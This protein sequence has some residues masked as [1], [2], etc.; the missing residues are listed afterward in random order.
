MRKM[1]KIVALSLV[2]AMALSMMAGAAFKDQA[3][4]NE[5]LADEISTLVALNVFSA[6]GTGEGYFEPNMTI[7]RAQA[8]KIIYVLK[9]KGVDNGA[10]SWTGLNIFAD[11]E[12][13]AWYEGYV[14]YCASTGILAG[15]GG[16]NYNPNGTLTGVELAKMLLVV[17]GYKA[18]V[19]G[20]T[21]DK[22][23]ENI[24][25]DAEVAGLFV[26]Y[27]LPVRGIVTREW[28]AKMI[29]NAIY[30]T[31][32]K[33][34]DGEATEMYNINNQP[35]TYAEQNLGLQTVVGQLV[36]NENVKLGDGINEDG[37]CVVTNEK[38]SAYFNFEIDN[39]LVGQNVKVIFKGET[40]TKADKIYGVSAAEDVVVLETTMDAV[41]TDD[42]DDDIVVYDNYVENEDLA[43][44][45]EENDAREVVLIDNDG[46]EDY[47]IALTKSVVYD[48]VSY[49]NPS[50]Y[51]L[52]LEGDSDFAIG[53]TAYNKV[54]FVDTVV[55]GDAVK[56][57]EDISSGKLVYNVEK[58]DVVTGTITKVTSAGVATID[59]KAFEAHV[60]A[61]DLAVNKTVLNYYVDKYV[62]FADE[63]VESEE[64]PT[65]IAL[66]ID[67]G[68]VEVE[69]TDKFGPT[70]QTESVLKLEIVTND[71]KRAIYE[72]NAEISGVIAE[73]DIE[74]GT[75]YEYVIKN[76]K[77]GLKELEGFSAEPSAE[78]KFVDKTN[79]V[80][81]IRTNEDS[82]FFVVTEDK[83]DEDE[84][85]VTVLSASEIKKDM[86]VVSLNMAVV[87]DGFNYVVAAAL[88]GGVEATSDEVIGLVSNGYE[89]ELVDDE[90]V[91]YIDVTNLDGTVVTLT[92]EAAEDEDAD[93]VIAKAEA[94]KGMF[95]SYTDAEDVVVVDLADIFTA[96]VL[97]YAE[98]NGL[99]IDGDEYELAEKVK[100]YYVDVYGDDNKIAITD[101]EGFTVSEELAENTKAESV[102][103]IVDDED[104]TIIT[105]I[106]VE[107]D[108]EE[109]VLP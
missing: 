79:K 43:A 17:I 1:N 81:G 25:A 94:I 58:L 4:I 3:A 11:V 50:K 83:D 21:G 8:A 10:T 30:A 56:I 19:E 12:A 37:K 85:V 78:A 65:N 80:D 15:V 76:E 63:V 66:V 59:G 67:G 41:D 29:V 99:V 109:I 44:Y 24:I 87:E 35:I 102:M 72:Y 64:I 9:N 88:N 90:T 105:E 74:L 27:E 52:K 14:N 2:L 22:W 103:F 18:D 92:L 98:D 20:Y 61:A 108:G 33:Y 69:K 68:V 36:A 31:K 26:D 84:I 32:V 106:I 70:G 7:T 5:D 104:A 86:P 28:A 71:G 89:S 45:F 48:F 100:I 60:D 42:L 75:I 51:M 39:A 97:E 57:T 55:K 82:I 91:V 13:G 47:E 38:G 54:N 107:V 49:I 53:K 40:L 34:E 101:G 96:G 46:D 73:D 77:L 6:N 16:N 93:D 23:A 62:V 95:I